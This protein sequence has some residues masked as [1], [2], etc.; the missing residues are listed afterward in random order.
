[1]VPD[2]GALL[3]LVVV[4]YGAAN[5]GLLVSVHF[6]LGRIL[7]RQDHHDGR[8]STHHDRITRLE[9]ALRRAENRHV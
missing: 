6:R 2:I 8:L 3:G 4:L 7:A 9:A 5:I 1:M